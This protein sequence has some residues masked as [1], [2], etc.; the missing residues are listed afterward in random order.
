MGPEI[1]YSFCHSQIG[2]WFSFL[3]AGGKDSHV[4][5]LPVR[6]KQTMWGLALGSLRV[7]ARWESQF[8]SSKSSSFRML[9]EFEGAAGADGEEGKMLIP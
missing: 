9:I 3:S 7:L 4:T 8:G 1:D 6:G 2:V 5:R